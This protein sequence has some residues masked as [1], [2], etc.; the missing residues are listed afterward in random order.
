MTD[1]KPEAA[2]PEDKKPD[3]APDKIGQDADDALHE[4]QKVIEEAGR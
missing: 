2:K 1:Q 4:A 3:P